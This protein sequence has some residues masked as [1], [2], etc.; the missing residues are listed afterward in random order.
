MLVS[1]CAIFLLMYIGYI[2]Q[3]AVG[4]NRLE[5]P[6]PHQEVAQTGFSIVIPLRN[7][8]ENLRRLLESISELDYPKELFELI[9]IDDASTD[10][11]AGMINRWRMQHGL[12]QT[13]V[14]ENVQ[15]TPSPKK[16]AILRAVPIARFDWILTTDADCRLPCSWL[17]AFDAQISTRAVEMIAGPVRYAP[18][19]SLS[20]HFQRMD[21]LSLQAVTMGSFG[22][23]KPFMCNGANFGYTK[24]FF[25]ELG[26]FSG[27]EKIASG[28]DVFLLQKAVKAAPEKV[29]Y[30]KSVDAIVETQPEKSWSGLFH[31]RVRWAA[32]AS[33]YENDYADQLAAVVLL[34]NMGVALTAVLS[35]L[36]YLDWRVAVGFFLAK[37]IP[38]W[39]IMHRANSFLKS[40]SILFPP[41][42]AKVYPIFILTVAGY[43]LFGSYKWKD[44]RFRL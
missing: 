30:L 18:L 5:K 32:K 44:R 29:T 21:F 38:D 37:L 34:V 23:G 27:N 40:Y 6:K 41:P 11:S 14:I 13:T 22:M 36:G 3:L 1:V 4:I 25:R 8:A 24:K 35:A 33:A 9:F 15:I 19:Q 28:D 12:F 20:G 16:N 17:R 10:D 31:Q 2:L 39:I 42:V 7:E 43:T 26:G